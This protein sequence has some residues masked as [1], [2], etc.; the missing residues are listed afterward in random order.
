MCNCNLIRVTFDLEIIVLSDMIR[1]E[2][3]N[4]TVIGASLVKLE[5]IFYTSTVKLRITLKY[6]T[7]LQELTL[8]INV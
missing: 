1:D 8:F 7:Q 2:G 5:Y 4:D 6:I 3:L